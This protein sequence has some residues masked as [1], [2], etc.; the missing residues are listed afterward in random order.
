[1]IYVFFFW[2]YI[3]KF[4]DLVERLLRA[5]EQLDWEAI[6]MTKG[7][8]RRKRKR[9]A[10]RQM[11]RQFAVWKET[12]QRW[13]KATKRLLTVGK[14]TLAKTRCER[15]VFTT[16]WSFGLKQYF[17]FLSIWLSL[18]LSQSQ[19]ICE[20]IFLFEYSFT[21]FNAMKWQT[22]NSGLMKKHTKHTSCD[23]NQ[24]IHL[25]SCKSVKM[26]KWR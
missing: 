3:I 9:K 2:N 4:H 14:L 8:Q 23:P 11:E 19:F 22:C 5:M 12:K 10:K 18:K 21:F 15:S 6:L 20:W 13:V 7:N 1:M 26:N 17:G 16:N 24:I 25:T